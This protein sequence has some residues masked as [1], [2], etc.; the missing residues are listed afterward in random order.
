MVK[1]KCPS[2]LFLFPILLLTACASPAASTTPDVLRMQYTAATNSW[3]HDLNT[4]ATEQGITLQP[5]LRVA[6]TLDVNSVILVMRIGEADG[7]SSAVY[8]IGTEEIVVIVNKLNP[9]GQLPADTVRGLFN[10]QIQNWKDVNGNDTAVQVWSFPAGED[11]EQVFVAAALD[12]GQVTPASRIAMTPDE[13]SLAIA[14][15]VN[16]IGIL[17]KHWKAGNISDV[18]TTASVPVLAIFPTE[19]QGITANLLACLQKQ[20][21]KSP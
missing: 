19:P 1:M 8:Q 10:G 3:L 17:S 6:D 15:D 21:P 11:V 18:F 14:N 7:S 4:C 2:L 20:N 5:E 12:G 16:A 13:M 9:I